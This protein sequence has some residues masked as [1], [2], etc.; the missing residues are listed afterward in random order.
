L[1][2]C[3]PYIIAPNKHVGHRL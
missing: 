3:L 1:T 2:A